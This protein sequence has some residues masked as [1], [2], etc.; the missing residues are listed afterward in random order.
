MIVF[1]VLCLLVQ[2]KEQDRYSEIMKSNDIPI[3]FI[4]GKEDNRDKLDK[5]KDMI[6]GSPFLSEY[7]KIYE[8]GCDEL[9][10]FCELE[11]IDVK[12]SILIQ[13]KLSCSKR[14]T[15][16]ESNL[17]RFNDSLSDF[18]IKRN[19]LVFN[20]N[21]ADKDTKQ[22]IKE[23]IIYLEKNTIAKIDNYYLLYETDKDIINN[24]MIADNS[25]TVFINN[26]KEVFDFEDLKNQTMIKGII[27]SMMANTVEILNKDSLCRIYG[28]GIES[29]I[30]F[31]QPNDLCK[32][33][34]EFFYQA[35]LYN[36][37]NDLFKERLQFVKVDLNNQD[38]TTEIVKRHLGDDILES[39]TCNII[40][41]GHKRG[42]IVKYKM[43]SDLINDTTAVIDFVTKYN[44]NQLERVYIKSE[45][46]KE[47]NQITADSFKDNIIKT[48]KETF[49]LICEENNTIC[50]I[51]KTYCQLIVN[52]SKS[53]IQFF[54]LDNSKNDVEQINTHV[55]PAFLIYKRNKK[56]QPSIYMEEFSY[57][58]VLSFFKQ[59]FEEF[60]FTNKDRLE[61]FNLIQDKI[62]LQERE[63]LKE[64]LITELDKTDEL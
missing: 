62:P 58:G 52:K 21:N 57:D 47:Q 60:E 7:Y 1:F 32:D 33:K 41:I 18:D 37:E 48:D 29:K 11:D 39:D 6:K 27:N 30:F 3:V 64:N 5:L 38:N 15:D 28:S 36:I 22:R 14:I 53:D 59:H 55:F 43:D 31:L 61:F 40:I 34:E 50:E 25:L 16:I 20:F 63:V 4:K 8:A 24:P 17:S 2:A 45:R 54:Y 35:A 46:K 49:L 44:E 10:D 13:P 12:R 9:L 51:L 26:Q 23:T 42:N 56:Y 19:S